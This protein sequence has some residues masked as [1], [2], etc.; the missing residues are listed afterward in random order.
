[1][2]FEQIKVNVTFDL[3]IE[4]RNFESKDENVA[5][6]IAIKILGVLKDSKDY[7]TTIPKVTTK[8]NKN[9]D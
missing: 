7:L 3:V 8:W 6:E 5:D 2:S 9:E 4:K 1:M